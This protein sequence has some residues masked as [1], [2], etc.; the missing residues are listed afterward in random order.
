MVFKTWALPAGSVLKNPPDNAG[1][2]GS[3]PG[4]ERSPG[5]GDGNPL[6]NSCLESTMDRGAWWAAVLRVT[7]S[8]T[9]LSD[10]A[11]THTAYSLKGRVDSLSWICI[12]TADTLFSLV[13]TTK[14]IIN[15][16]RLKLSRSR[17]LSDFWG[18]WAS[19]PL[20]S[21][22]FR[23]KILKSILCNCFVVKMNIT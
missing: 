23:E 9:W 5:G 4:L 3:I 19:L 22:S 11:H 18:L 20:W 10:W 12:S 8:Q 16:Q 6:Q 2:M 14:E 1:D 15:R 17:L 21:L 13:L 7:K